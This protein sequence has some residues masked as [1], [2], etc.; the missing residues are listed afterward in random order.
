MGV[1]DVVDLIHRAASIPTPDVKRAAGSIKCPL[2][3][4]PPE[5][6]RQTAEAMGYGAYRAKRADGGQGYGPYNWRASGVELPTY[7][8]ALMRHTMAV[9]AGEWLDEG[10]KGSGLPH[11]AMIAANCAVLLDAAATGKLTGIEGRT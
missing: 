4:L 7:I 6:L 5:F 3:L 9:A 1:R 2:Q 10:E 11:V 8:G